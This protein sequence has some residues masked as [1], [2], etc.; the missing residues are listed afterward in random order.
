MSKIIKVK[1]AIEI[2]MLPNYLKYDG[3]RIDIKDIPDDDLRKIGFAWTEELMKC[4]QK[5][6]LKSPTR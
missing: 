3:G 5:R 6:R 2:P 4:A 1:A